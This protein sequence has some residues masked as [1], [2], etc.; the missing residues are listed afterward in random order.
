V[1][2]SAPTG[3]PQLEKFRIRFFR[4]PRGA[5]QCLG[6]LADFAHGAEPQLPATAG[7]VGEPSK[8][9]DHRRLKSP[10]FH[11]HCVQAAV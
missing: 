7:S 6:A 10:G 8:F 9:A 11:G 1:V 5:R 2:I 3:N 4:L